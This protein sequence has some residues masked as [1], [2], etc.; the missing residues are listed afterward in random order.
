MAPVRRGRSW[1]CPSPSSKQGA[2]WGT[3]V[4]KTK[5]SC[6]SRTREVRPCTCSLCTSSIDQSMTRARR[7]YGEVVIRAPSGDGARRRH[8]SAS[9][10]RWGGRDEPLRLLGSREA[11][12]DLRLQVKYAQRIVDSA[13]TL[14]TC[15]PAGPW[16]RRVDE[17]PVCH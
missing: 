6:T 8:C 15:S 7:R 4:A 5:S 9:L 12:I 14:L 11:L 17:P 13:H 10:L 16:T 3:N 1:M 2:H